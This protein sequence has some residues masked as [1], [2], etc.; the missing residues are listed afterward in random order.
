MKNRGRKTTVSAVGATSKTGAKSKAE[1]RPA[2]RTDETS[3]HQVSPPPALKRAKREIKA[4]R[5]YAE[6]IIRTVRNPLVVLR[7]DFRINTANE[8]FYNTFGS[9]PKQAEGCLIFDLAD[10]AWQ[11]PKLRMWLEDIL[12]R[13]SFFNDFEVTHDFPKIGRR[14][15]LLNARRLDLDD[16]SPQMILLSIEDVTERQH[17]DLATASLAAIVNS[18]DDAIISKDLHGVITS[19]NQGAE[20]LFGYTA[21]EAVGQPVAMLIPANRLAE[22]PEILARLRRGERVDHF[23][24]VRLRKSGSTLDISLTISPIRNATGAIIGASK[25]ARDITERKQAQETLR[26]SEERYRT[27]FD[28]GPVAVYSCDAA[29]VIKEFNRRAA[30]LWG[31]QPK[32]GETDERFCGSFQLIS[33]EGGIMPHEE[34]P[35]AEVLSG[36]I[37]EAHDAEV[38]IVRPD[39]SRITVVV[40]IHPLKTPDGQITGAINCFYDITERKRVEEALQ[41]AQ[42]QLADRTDQLEQAVT[43]RTGELIT[44]NKQLEAFI[45]SIAHDLRAPLRAMQGFSAMLVEE[46]GVALSETAQDYAQRIS[47]SSQFMD[48]MLRD[49]LEFSRVSQQHLELAP[50]G[51]GTVVEGILWRLARDIREKNARV[52]NSGPWPFVLAHE[53]TLSQ[54]LFNLMSN[55][56]KFVAPD[57]APVVRLRTEERTEFI[58]VWVEDNGIGIAFDYQDQIFRLFARLHGE[59]YPGTGVGLAIVQKGVE[60]MGGRVGMESA[61]GQG[62]RFWFELKKSKTT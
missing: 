18:S 57:V 53:P 21:A 4:A 2:V 9:T 32:L 49:L 30:E 58:R 28:L 39:A 14:T 31:R 41:L 12:P 40:N 7:A 55:A 24:T 1:K 45:Y 20:R 29:G 38:I 46:A 54:V 60:R 48:A 27:L 52:E 15:M 34:C 19:W 50:V 43:E 42:K 17:A 37:P 62:S 3:A 13:N 11:I 22:E 47:K 51:L 6:G 5:E 10:G 36:K 56:L 35:M 23:E 61:P 33:P 8:A 25:I 59:K 44:T 26:A 16:G